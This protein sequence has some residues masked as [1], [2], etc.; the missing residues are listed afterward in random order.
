[1]YK[2]FSLTLAADSSYWK[3]WKLENSEMTYSK[4]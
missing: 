4:S 2:G 1:M 3:P